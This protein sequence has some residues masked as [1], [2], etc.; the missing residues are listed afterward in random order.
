MFPEELSKIVQT[1]IL[2]IQSNPD[3][4]AISIFSTI[5]SVVPNYI[6]DIT[7]L[8]NLKKN[9]PFNISHDFNYHN[10]FPDKT[11]IGL[12]IYECRDPT[13]LSTSLK[14]SKFFNYFKEL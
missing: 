11:A 3:V 13:T 12:L 8:I 9:Q 4:S 7:N 2:K 14:F 1:F 10:N 6:Y 5:A